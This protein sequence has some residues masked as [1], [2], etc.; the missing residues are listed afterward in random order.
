MHLKVHTQNFTVLLGEIW[1]LNTQNSRL[2]LSKKLGL[3][4]TVSNY[5]FR[6]TY[7]IDLMEFQSQSK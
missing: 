2:S 4:Q 3:S 1:P 5:R 6:I 7:P